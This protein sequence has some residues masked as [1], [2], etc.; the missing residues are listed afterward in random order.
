[1]S[2]FFWKKENKWTS[3]FIPSLISPNAWE[4]KREVFLRIDDVGSDYAEEETKTLE[5]QW[6]EKI[7]FFVRNRY[8]GSYILCQPDNIP[9]WP[10]GGFEWHNNASYLE[11]LLHFYDI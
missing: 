1:M 3:V 8:L 9:N 5:V 7:P 6:T 2:S 11:N 10:V 4:N